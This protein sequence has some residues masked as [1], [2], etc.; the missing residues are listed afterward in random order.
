MGSADLAVLDAPPPTASDQG[1]STPR[2]PT[3]RGSAL[4]WLFGVSSFVASGLMFAIEPMV[5][6]LMLP[7]LGGSPA[8]W[9]TA[10]VFF[11]LVLLLGYLAAHR[12]ARYT[13]GRHAAVAVAVAA[14]PLLVLPVSMPDGWTP[15][16]AAS[17]VW[18]TFLLLVLSVGAPFFALSTV[19]PTLQRW[20]GL[21]TDRDPYVLYATGN[22]GSLVAL[23]AY[24]LLI[25]PRFDLPT[26][27][28]VWAVAYVAFVGL[29]A[30]CAMVARRRTDNVPVPHVAP[31]PAP[32][33][34]RLRWC[35]TAA[36]PSA[37]LLGVTRHIATDI[38]SVPLLWVVPLALYLAT[39]IV[40]FSKTGARLVDSS[41]LVARVL[42]IPVV[43]SLAGTS[44]GMG[45]SLSLHL[46]AFFAAALL[47]HAR[48]WSPRGPN[49]PS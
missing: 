37:L 4:A 1:E 35:A 16:Q 44:L 33:P 47:A 42:V 18:W 10:L 3:R 34:A 15:P 38:A 25:E 21:A 6:K 5:A 30:S 14:I 2:E 32:W 13:P 31:T 49:R 28:R 19:S 22:T 40:A 11:Q 45:L 43:L 20:Y 29:L 7:L 27:T 8:V 36:I 9:N 39:F 24:P 48:V 17:P 23:L 41:G 46:S 12:L 26:Q